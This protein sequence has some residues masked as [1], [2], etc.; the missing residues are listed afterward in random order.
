MGWLDK[1]DWGRKLA[2]ETRL[3]FFKHDT[4]RS[5]KLRGDAKTINRIYD[6]FAPLYD[7]FFPRVESYGQTVDHI[8]DTLVEPG[9]RILDLGAG[10]GI[11]T[12]RMAPKAARV[13]ACD[14]NRTMLE[15]AQKK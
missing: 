12:V 13:V 6:M 8:V 9:D 10:T 2:R 3:F 11:L 7:F 4:L 5:A 14:L 1:F 15:R